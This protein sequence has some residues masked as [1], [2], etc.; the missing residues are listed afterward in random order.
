MGL[1]ESKGLEGPFSLSR[2]WLNENRAEPSQLCLHQG[3]GKRL[4]TPA[5]TSKVLQEV[6]KNRA[7]PYST[8]VLPS[9]SFHIPSA[10]LFPCRRLA[11]RSG[12]T[13]QPFLPGHSLR[14]FEVP[15]AASHPG[16]SGHFPCPLHVYFSCK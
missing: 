5:S 7:A 16:V 10:S 14:T 8:S 4:L 12:I 2:E 1:F 9:R 15:A 13:E 6:A 11:S 3:K